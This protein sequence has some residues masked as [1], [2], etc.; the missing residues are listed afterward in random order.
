MDQFRLTLRNQLT[1]IDQ[2]I[3][4]GTAETFKSNVTLAL[5]GRVTKIGEEFGEVMQALIGATG[6]NPRK[7]FSHSIDDVNDELA[8]V[9]ITA[10]CAMQH[11]TKDSDETLAI[12]SAKLDYLMRRAGL[13]ATA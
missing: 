10:L 6:Q 5:F 7:G 2:W 12:I 4:D 13:T 11:I 9:V 1:A 8:D 3:D